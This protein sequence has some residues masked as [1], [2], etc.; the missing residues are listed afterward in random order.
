MLPLD[1]F[2]DLKLMCIQRLGGLFVCVRMIKERAPL[3]MFFGRPRDL[4]I[5]LAILRLRNLFGNLAHYVAL[6]IDMGRS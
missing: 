5:Y 6:Y 1:A 2:E 3:R 4:E